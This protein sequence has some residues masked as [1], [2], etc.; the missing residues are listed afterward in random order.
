MLLIP[1]F[2]IEGSAFA[3]LITVIVYNTTKLLFVVYKINLFP[4]TIKTFYNL[5]I[6]SVIFLLFF[7]WDFSYYPIVNIVLKSVLVSVIY[8]TL[9]VKFNISEDFNVSL[10]FGF[11]YLKTM[12]K[13]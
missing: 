6:I 9:N 10:Q 2:G 7:Y 8:V 5:I 3:T 13:S 12:F 11:K 1:R 4:F